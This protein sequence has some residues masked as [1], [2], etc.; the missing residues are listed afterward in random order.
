MH[1]VWS[2]CFCQQESC[3]FSLLVWGHFHSFCPFLTACFLSFFISGVLKCKPCSV[4]LQRPAP[5]SRLSLS[6]GW[7]HWTV[8]LLEHVWGFRLSFSFFLAQTCLMCKLDSVL[9]EPY[10][11]NEHTLTLRT[12]HKMGTKERNYFQHIL[13]HVCIKGLV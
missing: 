2:M 1:V 3:A 12:T 13:W 9:I 8:R 4:A 10:S 11:L 7:I 5:A 6:P